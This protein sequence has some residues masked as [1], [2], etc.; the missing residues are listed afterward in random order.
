MALPSDPPLPKFSWPRSWWMWLMDFW[1]WAKAAQPLPNTNDFDVSE[2]AN[3]RV[4]SL[5]NK[6]IAPPTGQLREFHVTPVG[7]A[8]QVRVSCGTWMGIE[9]EDLVN[10][11]SVDGYVLLTVAD[12]DAIY[13][14]YNASGMPITVTAMA[15]T[16]PGNTPELG[17]MYVGIAVITITDGV[18]AAQNHRWGPIEYL[19]P[20]FDPYWLLDTDQED[21]LEDYWEDFK[22][23]DEDGI[24]QEGYNSVRF[25][26]VTRYWQSSESTTIG[27]DPFYIVTTLVFGRYGFVDSNGDVYDISA[28]FVMKTFKW[29]SPDAV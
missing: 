7:N 6:P 13:L 25:A 3:G 24:L 2:T 12:G 22:P 10:G 11:G 15:G 26:F 4:I 8:D 5:K 20:S 29:I 1:L 23:Y 9:L 27:G 14:K 19:V 28:E 21:P 16:Q 18:V 17:L